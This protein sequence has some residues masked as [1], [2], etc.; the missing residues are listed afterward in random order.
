MPQYRR[1]PIVVTAE[2]YLP[3]EGQ[4]PE[5]VCRGH[6]VQWGGDIP[7][8]TFHDGTPHVH[9][10]DGL[11]PIFPGDWLVSHARG[12]WYVVGPTDFAD[13]YEPLDDEAAASRRRWNDRRPAV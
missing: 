1:K 8:T 9:T 13:T 7:S 5:D 2:R 4:V 6:C 12:P 11:P 3:D 10:L